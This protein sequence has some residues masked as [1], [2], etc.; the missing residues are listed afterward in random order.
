MA[1]NN[2]YIQRCLRYE[3]KRPAMLTK[4]IAWKIHIVQPPKSSKL[5]NPNA[6][7]ANANSGKQQGESIAVR[8]S[9]KV[10][11]LSMLIVSFIKS[12]L[13]FVFACVT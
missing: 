7:A 2:G 3:T 1:T 6:E 13:M 10:P 5:P 8:N 12:I 9:P 11:N 4:T